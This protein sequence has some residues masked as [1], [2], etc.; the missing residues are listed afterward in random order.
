MTELQLNLPLAQINT[1]CWNQVGIWG[2]RSCPELSKV[3]HCQN[4]PVFSM[5]GRRFLDAPSPPNYSDEW[6]ARLA[7]AVT[8][9][10]GEQQ[11]VLIFRLADEW[12]AIHVQALVEVTLMK[13]IR[14][15]P[16]R[17]GI[18]IGMVNIRGELYLCANLA[19]ILGVELNP[20]TTQ[21]QRM[22]VIRRHGERWVLPVDE[23]DQVHQ[24]S[25]QDVGRP[26]ATVGRA[27][28]TLSFGLFNW[29]ERTVGLLDEDRI[30]EVLRAKIK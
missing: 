15:I 19:K 11:S 13:P 20:L 24:I 25:R 28:S 26:P 16:N 7:E 9:T 30:F 8:E 10:R 29:S 3:V 2:N 27:S 22:L 18:V 4:C 5:A 1:D 6:T 17:G 12:L 23:V 21:A 14:R